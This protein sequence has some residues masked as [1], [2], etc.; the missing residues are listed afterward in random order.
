MLEEARKEGFGSGCEDQGV[1]ILCTVGMYAMMMNAPD[2][3]GLDSSIPV[4]F[5]SFNPW[6]SIGIE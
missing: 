1:R 4:L 6:R 2:D 3:L 5:M